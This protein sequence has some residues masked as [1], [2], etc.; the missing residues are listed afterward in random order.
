[1]Y[2]S[3]SMWRRVAIFGPRNY[4]LDGP[5]VAWQVLDEKKEAMI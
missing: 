2:M 3:N 1:M 4:W 5:N